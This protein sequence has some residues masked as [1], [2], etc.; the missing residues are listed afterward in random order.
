MCIR[1]RPYDGI[2]HID[3]HMK[4]LDEETLLIGQ[5]PAGVSDGPQLDSNIQSI[6][7][8]YNSVFGTPY[9]I[10]RIPMPSSTGGAYPPTASYRTFANNLFL[11][12]T[13]IVPTYRP[14]F[15]TTGLRILAESLPGYNIVPI[16]CDESGMNIISA[17]GAI[18][19]LTCLLYTSPSPRD[20]TRS[21]MPSSA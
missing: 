18:H 4:L 16:D 15:D 12:K 1:D 7:A 21:R 3:M 17:S 19:C 14:Q 11:N 20:R 9:R 2:H 6:L 8:N 13:V 5:F 10:V